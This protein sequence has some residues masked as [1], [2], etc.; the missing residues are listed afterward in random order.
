MNPSYLN[1]L[2]FRLSNTMFTCLLCGRQFQQKCFAT[3]HI[4]VAA[5]DCHRA[6][7][8]RD[9]EV[10]SKFIGDPKVRKV[11]PSQ[12]KSVTAAESRT[13]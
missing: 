4:R 5:D 12:E 7:F 8:G 3:M 1:F 6:G 2:K 10:I 11:Q 13:A 9:V